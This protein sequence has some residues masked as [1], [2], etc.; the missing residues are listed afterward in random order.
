MKEGVPQGGTL[1]PLL[2]NIYLHYALDLWFEKIV[3]KKSRGEAY[4]TR[5]ADDSVACFQYKDD[6]EIYYEELKVRLGKFKLEI[7]ED[8]TKIIEFG[9][10]AERDAIRKRKGK[11]DT[12]DFLGFTHYCGVSNQ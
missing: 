5:F 3:K 1:S 4:I 8:K 12:F 10:F 2:A 7:A 9:R 6:A 11:P